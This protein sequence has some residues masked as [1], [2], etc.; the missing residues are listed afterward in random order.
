MAC[1]ACVEE[2]FNSLIR[3]YHFKT[4]KD[5]SLI[6]LQARKEE[7]EKEITIDKILEIVNSKCT[8][9]YKN[10]CNHVFECESLLSTNAICRQCGFGL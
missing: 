4:Y 6:K 8:E 5:H 9:C 10:N 3:I 1:K 2:I 7:I